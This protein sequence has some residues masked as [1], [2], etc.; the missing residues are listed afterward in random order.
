VAN[1]ER[2]MGVYGEADRIVVEEVRL[3]PL[4]YSRPD[5]LAMP[6]VGT[7]LTTATR[8]RCW[9]DIIVEPYWCAGSKRDRVAVERRMR[10]GPM[11]FVT[12]EGRALESS[13]KQR[14]RRVGSGLLHSSTPDSHASY[15]RRSPCRELLT[16][17]WFG[18]EWNGRL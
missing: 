1:R 13:H 6:W 3:I 10:R 2:R 18:L 12:A 11:C 7:R 15:D 5:L 14:A 9:K 16:E 4:S 17:K 8:V